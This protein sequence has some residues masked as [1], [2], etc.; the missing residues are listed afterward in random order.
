LVALHTP[1]QTPLH[2][3]APSHASN[4]STGAPH[5]TNAINAIVQSM[6]L[7]NRAIVA[8]CNQWH[9][10]INGVVQSMAI[11]QSLAIIGN[12]WHPFG[13]CLIEPR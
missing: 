7:C 1:L 12:H 13:V 5:G 9:C 6:A 11:V 3:L 2:A 8:P 10:A 4:A